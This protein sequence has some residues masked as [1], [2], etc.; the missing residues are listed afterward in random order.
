MLAFIDESGDPGRKLVRGSSRYF[1]VA[2]VTFD[3]NEVAADCD[4]RI[5]L[6]R[7]ELGLAD[8]YEFHF[9]RNSHRVRLSFLRAVSPY[10]FFYHGLVLNKDP[11]RLVGEGFNYKEPLYKYVCR[12][13]LTNARPYLGETT[14]VIDR[15]GAKRFQKEL[16]TY[17]KKHIEKEGRQTI[18]KVKSERS[19]SNNLLQLA[20]YVASII[21][22]RAQG[23]RGAA[24]YYKYLATKEITCQIWPKTY[25]TPSP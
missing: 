3:D 14:I 20:D 4:N 7:R 19:D 21:N 8:N 6:L 18:K 17:L 25:P 9:S 2:V 23:K 15:S 13:V 16:A 5:S 10:G 11:K 1:V 12:L 22:R 24:E